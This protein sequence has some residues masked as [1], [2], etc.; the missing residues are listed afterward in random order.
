M[1]KRTESSQLTKASQGLHRRFWKPL[2]Q[3]IADFIPVL[4]Q[5]RFLSCSW[6][7][8]TGDLCLG[9]AQLSWAV[10]DEVLTQDIN[11]NVFLYLNRVIKL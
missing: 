2:S 9:I 1:E 6:L 11:I 8:S 4:A 5:A 7:F 10:D 3:P